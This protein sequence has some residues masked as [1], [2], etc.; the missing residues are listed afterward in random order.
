MKLDLDAFFAS[1][2]IGIG[3]SYLVAGA[4]EAGVSPISSGL[5]IPMAMVLGA[6][7]SALFFFRPESAQP[8][9]K[10]RAVSASFGQALS[11]LPLVILSYFQV[12]S[13]IGF[14]L[15]AALYY[16]F[17]FLAGPSWTLW[18]SLLLPE[19]DTAR[20]F[21]RRLRITQAGLLCGLIFGGYFLHELWGGLTRS[22]VFSLVFALALMGRLVSVWALSRLQDAHPIE[23]LSM[24]QSVQVFLKQRGYRSLFGFLFVFYFIIAIS[25]PF[26]NPYLL[27]ELKL[28]YHHYMGTI[29]AL[30]VGKFL[31]LPWGPRW[32]KKWGVQKLL[33]AGALGISPLPVLWI[34]LRSFEAVVLLQ[35]VSGAFWAIFEM[36]FSV[37]FFNH[38]SRQEKLPLLC[39]YNLFNAVAM[40]LGVLFGAVL[41]K[42]FQHS[43]DL[44]FLVGASL[45]TIFVLA[46][47]FWGAHRNWPR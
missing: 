30:F 20:F 8:S 22:Q 15:A 5:L 21:S 4:L 26:V 33:L 16:F 46:I 12:R 3:E 17:G 7:L 19:N 23:S 14:L 6:A 31:I 28:S 9:I 38:L 2:M 37:I 35:V 43:Y 44:M 10:G 11:F 13:E 42:S 29:A 34:W 47:L 27:L 18:I 24:K 1:L 39:W 36:S 32:I 41:L 45:R 40:A 25:S